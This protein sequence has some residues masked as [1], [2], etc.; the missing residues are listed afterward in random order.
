MG[1]DQVKLS[2]KDADKQAKLRYGLSAFAIRV[3]SIHRNQR[4][5]IMLVDSNSVF[6]LGYGDSY[7]S[8]LTMADKEVKA[9]REAVEMQMKQVEEQKKFELEAKEKQETL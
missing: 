2:K 6:A 9:A 7:E 4:F 5:G 8:A 1:I 3:S